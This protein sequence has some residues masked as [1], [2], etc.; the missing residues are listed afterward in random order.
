MRICGSTLL[1]GLL[2]LFHPIAANADSAISSAPSEKSIEDEL[3]GLRQSMLDAYQ[4]N[5][6]GLMPYLHPDII[7]TWQDGVVSKGPEGV[8]EYLRG[9][10]VGPDSIVVKVSGNPKVMD[11]TIFNDHILSFG[12]MNDTFVLRGQEDQPLNFNSRFSSYVTR[13][14]GKLKL[15]GM[16]MSV[17]AFDNPITSYAIA[18]VK[19]LMIMVGLGA[20]IFGFIIGR[21]SARKRA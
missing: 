15:A 10:L 2:F 13:H 16:H 4:G 5:I 14:E 3:S 7:V 9:K 18:S 12:N 19:K 8:R 21:I 6:D 17:N 1:F 11:R 20:M